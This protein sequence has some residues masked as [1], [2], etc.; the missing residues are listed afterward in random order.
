MAKK[1]QFSARKDPLLRRA[2]RQ[3]SE[4]QLR[5][6]APAAPQPELDPTRSAAAAARTGETSPS[7]ASAPTAVEESG[8]GR[9][10]RAHATSPICAQA[11]SAGARGGLARNA[12]QTR[13]RAEGA[14]GRGAQRG[15][16]RRRCRCPR[17][18]GTAST[19]SGEPPASQPASCSPSSSQDAVPETPAGALT[20]VEQLLGTIAADEG[21]QEERNYRLPLT[22]RA[23][24]DALSEALG[25]GARVRSLLIR[26]LL[27][28]HTPAAPEQLREL[29]TARRI[30]S[31]RAALH[32]ELPTE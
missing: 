29:I 13:P 4:R 19:S 24:L 20:A 9:R 22:L 5:P 11:A 30:D 7:T 16:C 27:A 23:E 21:L 12:R 3:L 6:I 25:S 10:R 26:A 17:T 15:A 18:C 14:N 1:I 32:A 2:A 8:R 31:M 28:S